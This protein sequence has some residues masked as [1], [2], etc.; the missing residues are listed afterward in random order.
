MVY[1]NFPLISLHDKA[2]LAAQA[3]EAAGQQGKF[4]EL[5]DLLFDRQD[6]WTQLD[7]QDFEQWIS[8]QAVGLGLD[9]SRFKTDLQSEVIVNKIRQDWTDGQKIGLPGTPMMLINGQVYNG[10]RD[11]DS[12]DQ[13]VRLIALGKRQFSQCPPTN[14]DPTKQYLA[15]LDTEKGQIILQL[16]PDKAPLAVNNF[17][18]L[19]RQGWYNDITFHRV[20][21]GFVAQTGDPSGTGQGN[22]GYL[23][24]N[25][26]D[27]TLKFDKPGVVGMA[28]SG[29][30]TNGSQF[31]ITYAAEPHL[32]GGYTIF[33]QVISGMDVLQKLT[34]RDPQPSGPA[35]PPGDKLLDVTIQEK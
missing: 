29:A 14:I 21:P 7:S 25:E 6:Q 19:A 28:N 26:I 15:I 11:F 9:A 10:P 13:I 35:L 34:P 16:Y 31:F 4:W 18:Y 27:P 23:F 30:D 33:G 12:L 1:R 17:V 2:A 20:I 22:P 32:D 5:H 3:A 8:A 24:R